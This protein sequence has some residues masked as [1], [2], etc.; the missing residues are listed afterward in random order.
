MKNYSGPVEAFLDHKFTH[1]II[2]GGTAG[3]VVAARLSENP[4]LT[5][6]V[7]EAGPAA[8]EERRI[9]VP[10]R[11]SESLGS[12]YD[13][14]FETVAQAGVNGRTLPWARGKVL[15]GS[16]ALNFMTW[17]RGNREDYD[18]WEELGNEGWG[19]D[20]L[21]SVFSLLFSFFSFSALFCS[22][23]TIQC[24]ARININWALL[25]IWSVAIVLKKRTRP[26]F[27]KSEHLHRPD[28]YH[29]TRHQSYFD[30]EF[31]G[32]NGPLQTTYCLE[33]GASHQHW[34]AT[35]NK[36]GVD[37]NRSHCSGSNVGVW[38][39]IGSVDPATRERS[40][41]ATA[42]YRP[43]ADRANL[44][45][46]TEAVVRE[47]VLERQEGE[48]VAK[49]ARFVHGKKEYTVR[50]EGEVIVCAGAVQSPQLLELSGIGNPRVLQAAGID[51]KIENPSVG[52]NLQDHLSES[53]DFRLSAISRM[54]FDLPKLTVPQ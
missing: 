44:V 49:G 34:H 13:W 8:F 23:K 4:D 1:L 7:L 38:T 54:I 48:W 51:I 15:G 28:A 16:S 33:Y 27:K 14:K 2:G 47:V 3:L 53:S 32:T 24:T 46:L 41:S 9:N 37:T 17:N 39:S 25:Q 12:E 11:L 29:Q 19:W 18:A 43:N 52:E 21:L 26:F 36:L 31:H 10:G 40:Y 45:L 22:S 50:T 42:Y 35:L 20:G 5:V 30:T 6:G